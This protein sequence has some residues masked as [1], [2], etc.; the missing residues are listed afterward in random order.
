M[1]NAFK[2]LIRVRY[3]ECDAQNVVFNAR[4]GD[5]VD[6]ATTEYVRELFGGYQQ[7]LDQG[8]DNQVVRLA[9]DWTSPARFDDVIAIGVATLRVGTSSYTLRLEFT[10]HASD[11]AIA[12][13]EITYVA[14]S[15]KNHKKL[16]LPEHFRET[17]LAGAGGKW[18]NYSGLS[19]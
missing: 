15:P 17:L 5:Y 14:V 1:A 8:I 12:I 7:L 19:L 13:S 9:T 11:R 3:G 16:V 2:V 10:D 6:L 18:V 4:Y